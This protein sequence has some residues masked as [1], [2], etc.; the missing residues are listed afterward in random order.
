[1]NLDAFEVIGVDQFVEIF[2][3]EVAVSRDVSPRWG[4]V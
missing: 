1:V 3:L 2:V 4:P